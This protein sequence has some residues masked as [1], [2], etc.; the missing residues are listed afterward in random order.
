MAFASAAASA[1]VS[2]LRL[3]VSGPVADSQFLAWGDSVSSRLGLAPP[4]LQ[5]GALE[6]EL[7]D[8]GGYFPEFRATFVR[9]HEGAGTEMRMDISKPG[10]EGERKPVAPLHFDF[11]RQ[12]FLQ[13]IHPRMSADSAGPFFTAKS[14]GAAFGLAATL[15]EALPFYLRSGDFS[16]QSADGMFAG[17]L[18]PVVG[19]AASTFLLL[20]KPWMPHQT[21]VAV[22]GY[23]VT[24]ILSTIYANFCLH[25]NRTLVQSGF[26]YHSENR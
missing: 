4:R 6:L 19:D 16:L 10:S 13:V 24:R 22:G 3:S 20:D 8:S 2:G 9:S 11:Y 26:R 5:E 1:P 12:A 18:I 17:L 21:W 7:G 25:R 14:N 23:V 15:P